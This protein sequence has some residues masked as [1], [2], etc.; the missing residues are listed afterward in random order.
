MTSDN[1]IKIGKMNLISEKDKKEINYVIIP[2]GYFRI[3]S[4][5]YEN[6]V[7]K[8][9]KALNL[10]RPEMIF[11]VP[12]NYTESE[13]FIHDFSDNFNKKFFDYYNEYD[14]SSVIDLSDII[15]NSPTSKEDTILWTQKLNEH[16]INK[17]KFS[18][19]EKH[20]EFVTKLEKIEY[21][22]RLI[23]ERIKTIIR[24]LSEA[25]NQA[26]AFLWMEHEKNDR[27]GDFIANSCIKG[28]TIMADCILNSE[29]ITD[30][31]GIKKMI[32]EFINTDKDTIVDKPSEF[33]TIDFQNRLF[34]NTSYDFVDFS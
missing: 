32:D 15:E 1:F 23:Y 30:E 31:S 28:T 18:F 5:N 14:L 29:C 33:F 19:N 11:R 22:R 4:P 12:R 10:E 34:N 9:L 27:N 3:E 26:N 20:F 24:G 21:R 13:Y 8:I 17:L 16:L 6:K 25:F 7:D 2:K